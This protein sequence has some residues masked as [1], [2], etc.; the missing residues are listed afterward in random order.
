MW[1]SEHVE[2]KKKE[3]EKLDI[4]YNIKLLD[5][6]NSTIKINVKCGRGVY[7]R[8][9]ARDIAIKLGTVGYL[10]KLQRTRI[11]DINRKECIT[12]KE[13]SEWLSAKT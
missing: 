3:N 9:L 12:I 10:K 1:Q 8:S 4:I 7:I 5:F 6:T 13:F 2:T 11:A